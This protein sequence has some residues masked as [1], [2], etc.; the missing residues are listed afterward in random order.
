MEW[1]MSLDFLAK[2]RGGGGELLVECVGYTGV[3]CVCVLVL[4][5][6]LELCLSKKIVHSA[7][8]SRSVLYLCPTQPW[9]GSGRREGGGGAPIGPVP[10]QQAG[11]AGDARPGLDRGDGLPDGRVLLDVDGPVD[12]LVPD[13]RLVGPVHHVDLHLHRPGQRRRAQV[14]RDRLQLVA[15]ALD[16]AK[17]EIRPRFKIRIYSLSFETAAAW[18]FMQ[19]HKCSPIVNVG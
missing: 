2:R 19:A 6:S 13:G 4:Q 10:P 5:K 7:A 8:A 18:A 17:K 1:G 15:L 14:L 16:V 11:D 9:K 12:D 3:Y